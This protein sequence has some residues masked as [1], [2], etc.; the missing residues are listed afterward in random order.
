MGDILEILVGAIAYHGEGF[1]M[2]PVF[3][4]RV[5]GLFCAIEWRALNHV[6]RGKIPF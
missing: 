4:L 5:L 6:H 2:V 1:V 3:Y